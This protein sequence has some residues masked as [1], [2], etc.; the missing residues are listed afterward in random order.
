MCVAVT[1]ATGS[2]ASAA[3]GDVVDSAQWSAY[4]Y[5]QAAGTGLTEARLLLSP[6][7][8]G[9]VIAMLLWKGSGAIQAL[10]P[11]YL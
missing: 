6:A 3:T 11:T 10:L 9:P 8:S 7:K 2:S 1:R 4:V 5:T